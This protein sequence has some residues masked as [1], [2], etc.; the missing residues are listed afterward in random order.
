MENEQIIFKDEDGGGWI[1]LNRPKAMNALNGFIM[2]TLVSILH[3]WKETTEIKYLVIRGEG[4][5]FSGG[6]DL[7][8]VNDLMETGIE[9]ISEVVNVI[10]QVSSA[11]HNFS[12]PYIAVLDGIAI[13]GGMGIS[14]PGSHRIVTE[15]SRLSMPEAGIGSF[16]DMGSAFF[17]NNCPGKIGLYL[18]LTGK[19]IGPQDAFFTGLG[20][21]Y[22][23]SERIEKLLADIKK[24]KGENLDEIFNRYNK[25]LEGKAPLEIY[26]EIIDNCFNQPSIENIFQALAQNNSDFAAQTLSR[27]KV[28]SPLSL[29]TTYDLFMLAE[30]KTMDEIIEDNKNRYIKW[31]TTPECVSELKE[32]IRA[33]IIE[34]DKNPKWLSSPIEY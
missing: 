15:K 24:D 28:L 30:H 18:G 3:R 2:K 11:V 14:I 10:Y 6:G 19:S 13:G 23:P 26:Q 31:L 17:L 29:R 20:T 22:V 8:L 5:I 25:P 9:D 4:G 27:L 33:Y 7:T 16:P 34:K 1:I 12:K 21:H 32:G